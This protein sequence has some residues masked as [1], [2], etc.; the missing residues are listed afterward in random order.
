[1]LNKD[2]IKGKANEVMGTIKENLGVKRSVVLPGAGKTVRTPSLAHWRLGPA[3][4]T[5]FT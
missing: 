4:I 3:G 5:Q 2:E 1:M